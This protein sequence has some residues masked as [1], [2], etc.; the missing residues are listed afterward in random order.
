MLYIDVSRIEI[1]P[2]LENRA[3][4]SKDGTGWER[5]TVGSS[6]RLSPIEPSIY[7]IDC[8]DPK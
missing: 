2:L 6:Y 3:Q 5:I 4:S 1:L 8:D 7:R